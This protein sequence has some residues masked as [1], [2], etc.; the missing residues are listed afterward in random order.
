VDAGA[1]LVPLE[2]WHPFVDLRVV[3]FLL[4]IPVVPWCVDKALLRTAMKNDLPDLVRLRP[5]TPA[6]ANPLA[7]KLKRTGETWIDR[8]SIHPDLE[9]YVPPGALPRVTG[10]YAT[11]N[12]ALAIRPICLNVWLLQRS[13]ARTQGANPY[14][15]VQ[16]V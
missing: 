11:D 6:K 2:F 7:E 3:N 5:K 15:R 1:T 16:A 4:A 10:V 13:L 9:Q 12:V 14:V 8:M